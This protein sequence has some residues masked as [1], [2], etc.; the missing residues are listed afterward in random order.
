M[1]PRTR[2]KA[3]CYC[4]ENLRWCSADLISGRDV[5]IGVVIS[6]SLD[7]NSSEDQERGSGRSRGENGDWSEIAKV[8]KRRAVS[9]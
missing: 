5:K 3:T 2:E 9:A 8:F 6:Y 1:E 4:C 7:K